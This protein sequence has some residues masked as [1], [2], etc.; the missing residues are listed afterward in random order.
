MG[1]FSILGAVISIIFSLL[2]GAEKTII[3]AGIIGFNSV[4]IGIVSAMF[5]SKNEVAILV[6]IAASI[7]AVLIQ[8]IALKNSL[9]VFTLPFVLAAFVI[10]FLTR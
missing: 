2:V 8:V 3:F 10:F 4:L 6:T 1:I 5:I 9:P 7:L